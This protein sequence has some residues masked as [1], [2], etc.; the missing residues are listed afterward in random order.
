MQNTTPS[1]TATAAPPASSVAIP[2]RAPSSL[3]TRAVRVFLID[4]A[5][6]DA[7]VDANRDALKE[8]YG[9]VLAFT[10]RLRNGEKVNMG[11]GAAPLVTVR[12]HRPLWTRAAQARPTMLS[13]KQS[14]RAPSFRALETYGDDPEPEPT[15][16]E[17]V[18]EGLTVI[19]WHKQGQAKLAAEIAARRD[20]P[21]F[22][23]DEA[24]RSIAEHF[25]EIDR[26]EAV[27]GE[28]GAQQQPMAAE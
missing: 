5:E 3:P 20:D 22:R 11:G 12:A 18:A 23:V 19:A 1:P 10:S 15:A 25:N 21:Q 8:Q 9:S 17:V 24:R 16:A 13:I 4:Q 2:D 7:F 26:I 14:F 6:L 27:I 28:L